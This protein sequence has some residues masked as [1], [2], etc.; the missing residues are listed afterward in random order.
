MR[1][2]P[3]ERF[4]AG[5]E[6]SFEEDKSPSCRRTGFILFASTVAGPEWWLPHV[7]EGT[8]EKQ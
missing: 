5:V 8:K 4:G 1:T 7:V 2:L 6:L 3:W